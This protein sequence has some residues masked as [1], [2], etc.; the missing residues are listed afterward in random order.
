MNDM[1]K[2]ALIGLITVSIGGVAQA[3]TVFTEV[4]ATSGD[5]LWDTATNWSLGEPTGSDDAQ[6]FSDGAGAYANAVIKNYTAS[7]EDLSLQS[8]G[9]GARLGGNLTVEADGVLNGRSVILSKN[10]RVFNY[11]LIDLSTSV[12]QTSNISVFENHGRIDTDQNLSINKTATFNMLGG[13]FNALGDLLAGANAGQKLNVHGGEM[14]FVD[15]NAFDDLAVGGGNV[16]NLTIDFAGA[17]T[18]IFDLDDVT[19]ETRYGELQTII[20]AAMTAGHITTDGV[21]LSGAT[22]ETNDTLN[23]I[24]LTAIPEPGTYALLAGCFGLTW[25]MLRRRR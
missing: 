11:G 9:N 10:A 15:T 18:L 14:N 22:M 4:T 25:V 5:Y 12:V 7:V 19:G 6:I 8:G 17:G 23:T 2:T 21:A 13:E 20:G 3:Q 16:V 1:K 24:T